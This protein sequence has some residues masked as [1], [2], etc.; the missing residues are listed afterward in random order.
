MTKAPYGAGPLRQTPLRAGIVR[1][2]DASCK[3][4]L[5]P[6][7]LINWLPHLESQS[8]Q[9]EMHISIGTFQVVETRG[10][11]LTGHKAKLLSIEQHKRKISCT[12]F[13]FFMYT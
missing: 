12:S 11:I 3:P 10:D 1:Q 2:R 8:F 6:V 4:R 5:L 13:F 7:I 9:L